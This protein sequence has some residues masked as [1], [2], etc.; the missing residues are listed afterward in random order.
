ML[1]DEHS[2]LRQAK[3]VRNTAAR[4]SNIVN[5]FVGQDLR[6]GNHKPVSDALAAV[7]ISKALRRRKMRNVAI[8]QITTTLYAYTRMMCGE[9]TFLLSGITESD[10]ALISVD[11]CAYRSGSRCSRIPLLGR[12]AVLHDGHII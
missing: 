11:P 6:I 10:P 5:G 3:S 1:K 4:S 12:L 7:G 2:L 9:S 8:Q